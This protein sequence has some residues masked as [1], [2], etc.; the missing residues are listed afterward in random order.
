[1]PHK[2]SSFISKENLIK[3]IESNK[4]VITLHLLCT[5]CGGYLVISALAEDQTLHPYLENY[6][7]YVGGFLLLLNLYLVKAEP[8]STD[9]DVISNHI[10]QQ[11]GDTQQEQ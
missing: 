4:F 7:T 5:M 3:I 10:S 1:M 11:D 2:E 9:A 8:E 6:W